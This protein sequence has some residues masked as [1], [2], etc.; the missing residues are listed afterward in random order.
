MKT[1]LFLLILII[2]FV[3]FCLI[4]LENNIEKFAANSS[5]KEE[6][7]GSIEPEFDTLKE[8]NNFNKKADAKSNKITVSQHEVF[9]IGSLIEIEL[10]VNTKHSKDE[11]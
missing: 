7:K 10:L 4:S 8:K 3:R 5:E 2:F 6:K 9:S 1:I 11:V